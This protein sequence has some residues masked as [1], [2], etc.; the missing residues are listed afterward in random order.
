MQ[1]LEYEDTNPGFTLN[2]KSKNEGMADGTLSRLVKGDT[3][4]ERGNFKTIHFKKCK[5]YFL[6]IKDFI[7]KNMD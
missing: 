1:N 7:H 3:H 5:K 2:M 4:L 6:A